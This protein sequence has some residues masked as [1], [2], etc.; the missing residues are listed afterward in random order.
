M[1]R[2]YISFGSNIG[3]RFA[4]INQALQALR[5]A[6]GVSLIRVSSLYET[7]PVGDEAQDWFLNGVLAIETIL[8]P[9]SLLDLLKRIETRMGRQQRRRWGPREIDL[10]I[11]IYEGRCINTPDLIVPHPEMH[12]RRFVLVPFAEIAPDTVHPI[13]Q[14]TIQTLLSELTDQKAV[15]F[16]APPLF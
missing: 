5:E 9:H 2:A 12:R 1:A 16:A 14:Q 10:D 8:S 13:L 3:N 7:E 15:R 6:D 11:L 4:Y